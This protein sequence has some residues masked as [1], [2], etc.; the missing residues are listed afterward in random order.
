MSTVQ[1]LYGRRINELWAGRP[2]ATEIV[3]QDFV[4]H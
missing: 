4:G 1:E 2:I 3:T